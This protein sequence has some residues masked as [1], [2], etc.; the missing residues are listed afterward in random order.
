MSGPG[1][2]EGQANHRPGK[3]GKSTNHIPGFGECVIH[4]GS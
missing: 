4:E 2:G 3:E 1:G